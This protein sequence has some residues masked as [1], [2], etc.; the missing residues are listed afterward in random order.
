MNL[1]TTHILKADMLQPASESLSDTLNSFW[2]LESL[3]ITGPEKTVHYEF[4]ETV[5]FKDGKYQVSLPWKE[6]HKPLLRNYQLSLNRL[7]G[8]LR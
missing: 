6:F 2:E 7:W 3:G 8:L 5:T 4:V 1:T